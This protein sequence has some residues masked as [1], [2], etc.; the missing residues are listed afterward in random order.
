MKLSRLTALTVAPATLA[1][2]LMIGH[3]TANARPPVYETRAVVET[4]TSPRCITEATVTTRY[5]QWSTRAGHYV[6][7]PVP[8]RTAPPPR[9]RCHA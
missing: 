6:N 3:A 4:V 9:K 5:M 8:K 1:A 2:G 7:L